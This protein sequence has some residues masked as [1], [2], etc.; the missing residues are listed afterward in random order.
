MAFFVFLNPFRLHL[1]NK[2]DPL[3]KI[4]LT[5]D[6]TKMPLTEK[7]LFFFLTKKRFG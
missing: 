3:H 6:R 4:P 2:T 1:Q 7:V 5:A